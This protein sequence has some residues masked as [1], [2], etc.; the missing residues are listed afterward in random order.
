MLELHL[1]EKQTRTSLPIKSD[2]ENLILAT[3]VDSVDALLAKFYGRFPLPWEAIKFEYVEDQEFEREMI[4]QDLG[5]WNHQ[6]IGKEPQVWIG[7]CGT[8]QALQTALRFRG[9]SVIGSDVSG[10][11]LEICAR[12]AQ[13]LQVTNLELREESINQA[14]YK[15]QFD[16][17]ISTGVI[18]HNANPQGTLERLA[19]ALKPEGVLEL[20]VYNRFHRLVTSSFQ[21]AIRIFGGERG[22]VDFDGDLLLARKIINSVAVNDVLKTTAVRF[23]G[24]DES[25][26]ADLVAQPVEHS[27]TVESLEEMAASCGLELIAP[28]LSMFV[29]AI[30]SFFWNLTFADEEL[31]EQYDALP[32]SRRWQITNLLMHEHSPALWFYFQRKDAQH[33]KKPEKQICEEFLSTRFARTNAIQ[34]SYLRSEDGQYRL[35]PSR[36]SYPLAAPHPLLRHVHDAVDGKKT[37]REVLSLL[38][39]D[40]TFDV[41]NRIRIM[42]TTSAFPY[43]RALPRETQ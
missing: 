8:N 19:Q 11:S 32:D 26:L 25:D 34:R 37:M 5:D 14:T 36:V 33:P 40:A 6:R 18:H 30:G 16:Y 12:N 22:S 1:K 28:C 13:A 43:L 10:K 31:Q 42:L 2:D 4:N 21:K 39:I 20:M 15:E 17:V 24:W 7:G 41:V 27:Y 38:G 23:A 35:S 9:G 29:K 3:S